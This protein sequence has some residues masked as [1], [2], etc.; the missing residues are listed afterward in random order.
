MSTTKNIFSVLP[1]NIA[2][3]LTWSEYREGY[4]KAADTLVSTLLDSDRGFLAD[5]GARFGMVY[6]IMF[7]YR[8]Y[9]EIAFK[10][11]L[12]LCGMTSL[13]SGT[14]ISG[15]DLRALWSKVLECVEAVQGADARQDFQTT[16][17]QSI[18]LFERLDPRGDG[19]RYPKNVKGKAQWDSVFEIDI[20]R[21][22]LRIK[23]L[24]QLCDDLRSEL[25][26]MLDPGADVSDRYYFY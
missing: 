15:H 14:N 18:E 1:W 12:A 9:T 17:E 11:L 2:G 6:P 3:E 19:F 16:F 24:G 20:A 4:R 8:H 22:N 23:S 7:L 13:V 5:I 21:I 25:K 10:E 26:Q